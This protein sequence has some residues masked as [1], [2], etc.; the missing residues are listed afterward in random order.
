[1]AVGAARE[2]ERERGEG[3]AEAQA[4]G[5]RRVREIRTLN[6]P[7]GFGCSGNRSHRPPFGT[8]SPWTEAKQLTFSHF[9][10]SGLT[11]PR[12]IPLFGTGFGRIGA[13]T[14]L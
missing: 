6:K 4:R 3:V 1:V 5:K 11:G 10:A 9:L 8:G 12:P 7:Y 13:Y 14:P 2:R